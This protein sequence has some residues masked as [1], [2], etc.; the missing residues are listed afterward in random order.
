MLDEVGKVEKF[1]FLEKKRKIL[2][3]IRICSIDNVH[4]I[5]K[6]SFEI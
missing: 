4:E 3:E 6:L 2:S 5:S 1:E